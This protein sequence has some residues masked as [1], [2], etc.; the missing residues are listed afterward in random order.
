MVNLLQRGVATGLLASLFVQQGLSLDLE[1]INPYASSTTT[2]V[3]IAGSAAE[4]TTSD[5]SSI[6]LQSSH[7]FYWGASS[8]SGYT[9]G[10][11]TVDKSGD[12][13]SL[14]AMEYFT[15]LL[16]NVT[17]TNSSMTL[18]FSDSDAYSY[19]KSSWSWVNGANN[20]TFVV[21]AGAGQCGWNTDRLPFIISA[22]SFRDDTTAARL[23]GN[24]STWDSVLGAFEL[25]LGPAPSDMEI[26]IT[27][28]GTES[29]TISFDH[30]LP[31]TSVKVL[32]ED[33]LDLSVECKDCETKGSFDFVFTY[34]VDISWSDLFSSDKKL[35]TANFKITPKDVSMDITPTL[36]LSGNLTKSYSKEAELVSIPLDGVSIKDLLDIG[37]SLVFAVGASAGPVNGDA[38]IGYGLSFDISND[39]T[40]ELDIVAEKATASGWSPT[41]T[42]TGVTLDA[43][44]DATVEVY[45]KA[46]LE[47]SLSILKWGYEA[48]IYLKPYVGADFSI[49]ASTSSVCEKENKDYHYAIGVQPSAGLTLD[50]D[51]AK[52]SDQAN[53]I[54]DVTIASLT[55]SMSSTCFGFGSITTKTTTSEKTSTT[56]SKSTSTDKT[57][58]TKTTD[59]KS[60]DTKS[61]STESKTSS[62]STKSHPSSASA[63]A[64]A[65]S[66]SHSHSHSA[67]ASASASSKAKSST[68][69]TAT[70]HAETTTKDSCSSQVTPSSSATYSVH[71]H[72]RGYRNHGRI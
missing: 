1:A 9:L 21:V 66:S 64:T 18:G 22:A 70:S 28:R 8:G 72:A 61:T 47:L 7:S 31:S 62:S 2:Q 65:H 71:N 54:A 69:V 5:Y 13:E 41:V 17:C 51:V 58:D 67:S 52:E 45:L 12:N 30:S 29:K 27:K 36:D 10:N 60:T 16:T 34:K 26:S 33:S 35:G 11:L 6:D 15:D 25:T 68:S 57:T 20:R 19:A 23:T 56:E 3:K 40:A 46:S 38:T 53:P 44:I 49:E 59:T 50:A 4:S 43:E 63:S 37:P 24:A 42:T 55:K 39:A 48:G 14:L 32:S